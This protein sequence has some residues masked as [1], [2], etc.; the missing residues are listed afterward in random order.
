MVLPNLF[1]LLRHRTTSYCSAW[2]SGMC[3]MFIL[4]PITEAYITTVGAVLC[5][6]FWLNYSVI[7]SFRT[8]L[9]KESD[10]DL[11]IYR[12][13]KLFDRHLLHLTR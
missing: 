4:Q 1:F 9:L 7:D 13:Y 10:L 6:L 2:Y 8:G 3:V 12:N 11:S 5:C